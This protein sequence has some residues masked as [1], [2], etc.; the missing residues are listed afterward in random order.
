MQLC[1][2]CK[3]AIQERMSFLNLRN[4]Y[5]SVQ[6]KNNIFKEVLMKCKLEENRQNF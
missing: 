5:K 2:I 1:C 4:I 6:Q 3:H